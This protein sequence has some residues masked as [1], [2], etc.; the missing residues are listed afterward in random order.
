MQKTYTKTASLT[1]FVIPSGTNIL[2]SSLLFCSMLLGSCNENSKAD[3][4]AEE[5]VAPDLGGELRGVSIGDDYDKV[6][7]TDPANFLYSMPDEIVYRLPVEDANGTWY[8]ITYNFNDRGLYDICLEI[9]PTDTGTNDKI[10]ADLLKLYSSKYGS[11]AFEDGY[12][13]W[14]IMTQNAHVITV[15]MTD[16]LKKHGKPMIRIRFNESE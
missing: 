16:S 4:V 5:I 7:Q 8:E 11:A 1:Y 14:K 10:L 12:S 9:F 6:L 3:T 2:W 13:T 15:N